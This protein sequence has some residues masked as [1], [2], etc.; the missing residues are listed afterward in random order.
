VLLISQRNKVNKLRARL[1][2]VPYVGEVSSLPHMEWTVGVS[3]VRAGLAAQ[4]PTSF[5]AFSLGIKLTW[6]FSLV[7]SICVFGSP[8]LDKHLSREKPFSGWKLPRPREARRFSFSRC[9]PR[10]GPTPSDSNPSQ[11]LRR[12]S[13]PTPS[14]GCRRH[15][16]LRH[17]T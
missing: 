12:R 9:H 5:S 7:L 14:L 3:T 15:E 8:S 11:L 2:L 1:K 13:S 17:R 4:N 10:D 6:I 16:L